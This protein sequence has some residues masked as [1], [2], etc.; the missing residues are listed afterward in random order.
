MSAAVV[1]ENEVR[2]VD[3]KYH[4]HIADAHGQ[5]RCAVNAFDDEA[6]VELLCFLMIAQLFAFAREGVWLSANNLGE[7]TQLWL[8]SNRVTCDW[9]ERARP[10]EAS[11]AI[12]AQESVH[13]FP[14]DDSDVPQL[15]NLKAG[16]FLDYRSPVVQRVYA[17]REAHLK[18]L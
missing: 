18:S 9:L 8:I 1:A 3:F 5:Y 13:P 6:R 17:L 4:R 16:R 10:V 12:A 15:F 11:R 2:S 7:T 14:K